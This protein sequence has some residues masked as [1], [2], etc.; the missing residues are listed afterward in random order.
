MRY[1]KGNLLDKKF[2]ALSNTTR[3]EILILLKEKPLNAG[4]IANYFTYSFASILNH[5][6]I[7]EE[8]G[9]VISKRNGSYK[10]YSLCAEALEEIYLWLTNLISK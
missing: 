8:S 5:L 9:L 10:Q 2:K 4:E 1:E 7:L 6:H 3:R